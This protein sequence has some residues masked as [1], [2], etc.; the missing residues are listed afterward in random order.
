M[1][2]KYVIFWRVLCLAVG[3]VLLGLSFANVVDS[4]WSG[5]GAGFIFVGALQLFRWVRYARN[6][7]YRKAPK[8]LVFY[9]RKRFS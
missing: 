7:E 3:G 2:I 4:F 9:R 5:M 1:K 8:A 6:E